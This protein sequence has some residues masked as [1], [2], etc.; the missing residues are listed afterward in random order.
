MT[1]HAGAGRPPTVPSPAVR[2]RPGMNRR[3]VGFAAAAGVMAGV[4]VLVVPQ[5]A[6]S[7]G[8]VAATTV[9]V[10][11]GAVVLRA[12]AAVAS[13]APPGSIL[14]RPPMA[15]VPPLDPHGLRDARRDLDRPTT[16]GRLPPA[17]HRRLV[18]VA[19]QAGVTVDPPAAASASG[20]SDA[21]SVAAL[22]NRALDQIDARRPGAPTHGHH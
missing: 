9:A 3:I 16:P 13:V 8:R 1:T 2:P 4:I 21:G 15:A 17:V 12:V 22:V 5:H 14:D 6:V 7:V 19:T 10:L 11:T 18:S 20:R